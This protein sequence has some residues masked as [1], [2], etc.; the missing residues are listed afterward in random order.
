MKNTEKIGHNPTSEELEELV[1]VEGWK[2]LGPQIRAPD[3]GTSDIWDQDH[4]CGTGKLQPDGV[5]LSN[6]ILEI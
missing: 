1:L 3:V 6:A 5:V 2:I 4:R